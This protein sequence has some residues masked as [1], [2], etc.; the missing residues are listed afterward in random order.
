MS[1]PIDYQRVFSELETLI[2]EKARLEAAAAEVDKKITEGLM[3]AQQCFDQL[4]RCLVKSS[5]D[6]E[7]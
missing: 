1:D 6:G 4:A 7:A 2:Q 3:L 5:D